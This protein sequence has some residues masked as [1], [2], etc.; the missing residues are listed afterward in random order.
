MFSND[1]VHCKDLLWVSIWTH[2][3]HV[4]TSYLLSY[5]H[6]NNHYLIYMAK[7][8]YQNCEKLLWIQ[9]T[10]S[11]CLCFWGT[12]VQLKVETCPCPK[13]LMTVI[14]HWKFSC[15]FDILAVFIYASRWQHN[16]KMDL[17]LLTVFDI[18]F[19]KIWNVPHSFQCNTLSWFSA[20]DSVFAIHFSTGKTLKAAALQEKS[21]NY[22]NSICLYGVHSNHVGVTN[23]MEEWRA[24]SCGGSRCF[25]VLTE[26]WIEEGEL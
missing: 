23:Y 19:C 15:C 8:K 1:Y 14:H 6:N 26:N 21:R 25:V 13:P 11:R 5:F 24:A 22:M 18:V 17:N 10:C 16:N 12:E 4:Q 20:S 3:S 2:S 9:I 7:K